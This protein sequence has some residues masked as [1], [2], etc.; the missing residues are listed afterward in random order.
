[1]KVTSRALSEIRLCPLFYVPC[2]PVC[3]LT[4]G[5]GVSPRCGIFPTC[6]LL[7]IVTTLFG[8]QDFTKVM[9]MWEIDP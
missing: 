9:V 1:M 8:L 7:P 6:R 2:F 4:T 5:C 3:D